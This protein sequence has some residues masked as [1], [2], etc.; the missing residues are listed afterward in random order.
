MRSPPAAKQGELGVVRVVWEWISCH[1]LR[2]NNV[3][4]FM[5]DFVSRFWVCIEWVHS[6]CRV[7]VNMWISVWISFLWGICGYLIR[8]TGRL[9]EIWWNG[10]GV[11]WELVGDE[12]R[13]EWDE[14]GFY[15]S[16]IRVWLEFD[17]NL[18]GKF[19]VSVWMNVLY[20]KPIKT[21]DLAVFATPIIY[22]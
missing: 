7:S 20:P 17:W 2:V 3:N 6:A 15:W 13:L 18:I 16:L 5:W 9:G 4:K 8:F 21:V 19:W 11:E 12:L 10:S 14:C 22:V 1:Y